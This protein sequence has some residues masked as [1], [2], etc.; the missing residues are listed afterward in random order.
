MIGGVL[1]LV[2]C[3]LFEGCRRSSTSHRQSKHPLPRLTFRLSRRL[4]D[5]FRSS[6]FC[7]PIAVLRMKSRSS[8]VLRSKMRRSASISLQPG[9]WGTQDSV[10]RSK[11]CWMSKRKRVSLSQD[12]PRLHT[13]LTDSNTAN[14]TNRR[15][16]TR[17]E[18]VSRAKQ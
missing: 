13:L 3:V 9:S 12:H 6:R 16:G 7:I 14:R 17:S 5:Q 18:H 8:G 2:W 4:L 10:M 15:R 11:V 1:S